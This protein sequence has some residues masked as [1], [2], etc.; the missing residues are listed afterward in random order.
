MEIQRDMTINNK[1]ART[2]EKAS[3]QFLIRFFKGPSKGSD[4]QKNVPTRKPTVA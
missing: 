2:K 3:G 4:V 1:L